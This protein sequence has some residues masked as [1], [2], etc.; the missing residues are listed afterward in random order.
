[1][2]V[3]RILVTSTARECRSIRKQIRPIGRDESDAMGSEPAVSLVA[4]EGEKA[5]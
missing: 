3:N 1:M 4:L 5:S 2:K